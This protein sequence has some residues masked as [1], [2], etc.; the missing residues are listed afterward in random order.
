MRP[1]I[2]FDQLL[3]YS[4]GERALEEYTNDPP[5]VD[6]AEEPPP[7]P[8]DPKMSSTRPGRR[9]VRQTGFVSTVEAVPI[10]GD[11]ASSEDELQVSHTRSSKRKQDRS[12]YVD[13]PETDQE[14]DFEVNDEGSGR[15]RDS[16]L[17]LRNGNVKNHV[18]TRSSGRQSLLELRSED[19]ASESDGL[20]FL[21]SDLPGKRKRK[22]RMS[23]G[24]NELDLSD[25][26]IGYQKSKRQRVGERQS[27]RSTRHQGGMT[28]IGE[29]DI[30][31]EDSDQAARAP[32]KVKAVGAREMFKTLPRNDEFRMRH[33]HECEV[34][35]QGPNF[36]QL[37]YCQGCTLSYH[38]SC[39]GHRTNREHLVTKVGDGDFVL[40]CRRC[41]AFPRKKD[42][43]APD[44]GRCSDCHQH[45]NACKAFRPRR[46]TAQEQKER[47]DNDG[48][49]PNWDIHESRINNAEN[50]LFRCMTCW[51]AFH[52][53]HLPSRS[54]MIDIDS[55]ADAEQRFREYSRDWKCKECLTAPAKVSGIIAWKPTDEDNYDPAFDFEKIDGDDKAYL[56]RWEG[57]SYF[58]ASWMPGAWV[59]GRTAFVMRKAFAKR[60]DAQHPKMRTEDAIPEDYLRTDIVLDIK[61]TSIVD[62]RTEEIDKARIREIQKALILSLI[63]I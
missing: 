45:G 26:E 36:A 13:Q 46:T 2:S 63:H 18:S 50:V 25:G 8:R 48:T 47:D 22:Q 30:F 35:S 38:K 54:D 4:N 16:R 39:L 24:S 62:I 12:Q 34:C 9:Q 60:E 31:R 1:Q 3:A 37:I 52:F 28:E 27:G 20:E 53:E 11:D 51:R 57:M 41:V 42:P 33:A 61:F 21:K 55:E 49:D 17:R 40:Q 19:D 14:D 29:N 59:W 43:V 58:R 32:V 10:S 7:P 5:E 44:H 23:R 56:I 6:D 15:K